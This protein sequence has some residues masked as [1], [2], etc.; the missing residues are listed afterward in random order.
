MITCLTFV[1]FKIAVFCS[2]PIIYFIWLLLQ[3][4]IAG[5]FI[6]AERSSRCSAVTE[7]TSNSRVQCLREFAMCRSESVWQLSATE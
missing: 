5:T 4:V 3:Q 7:A 2:W 1:F 6:Q